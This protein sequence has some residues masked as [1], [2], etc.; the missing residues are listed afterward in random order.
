MNSCTDFCVLKKILYLYYHHISVHGRYI[1]AHILR[2]RFAIYPYFSGLIYWCWGKYTIT[3]VPVKW[4]A[5]CKQIHYIK[6][7]MTDEITITKQSTTKLCGYHSGYVVLIS[8][9]CATIQTRMAA[10]EPCI[11][12]LDV[13]RH[14][15]A[16][17]LMSAV[18]ICKPYGS[19]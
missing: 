2:M 17:N 3:S 19:W 15:V 11:A 1:A 16:F 13:K 12:S 8:M 9:L 5:E 18:T 14:N 4:H 7:L 6:R 10:W